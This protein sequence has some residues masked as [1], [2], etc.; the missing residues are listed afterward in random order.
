[1]KWYN[2]SS[3]DP[4]KEIKCVVHNFTLSFVIQKHNITKIKSFGIVRDIFE[5]YLRNIKIIKAT[6]RFIDP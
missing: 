1:M 5:D 3:I 6:D 4:E 2:G